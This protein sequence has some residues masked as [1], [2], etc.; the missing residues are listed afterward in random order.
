MTFFHARQSVST[1]SE[2]LKEA[3]AFIVTL[4]LD[5]YRQARFGVSRG[6]A[7]TS[8]VLFF[9][10]SNVRSSTLSKEKTYV[11]QHERP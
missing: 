11:T 4:N 5:A 1:E 3:E 6:V 10:L 9:N 2:D 7:A 8:R